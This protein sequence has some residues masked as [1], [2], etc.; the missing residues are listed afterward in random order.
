V[1][2]KSDKVVDRKVQAATADTNI[3]LQ[4]FGK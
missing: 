3:F 2:W 1:P 4:V